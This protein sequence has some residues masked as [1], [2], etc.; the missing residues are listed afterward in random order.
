ML[1]QN[2]LSYIPRPKSSP[3]QSAS[4]KR[5][6]QLLN[7]SL[8][9]DYKSFVELYGNG[10]V[11]GVI[12]I[13]NPFSGYGDWFEAVLGMYRKMREIFPYP[14]YPEPGGLLPFGG[15][16][17]GGLHLMWQTGKDADKWS[18]VLVNWDDLSVEKLNCNM[19]D[20][21]LRVAKREITGDRLNYADELDY[22]NIFRPIF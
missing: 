17:N 1:P 15:T 16:Q 4:W 10:L 12:R 18:V 22:D 20:F 19:A 21:L 9:D 11:C 14:L 7:T 13:H 2:F 3:Y 6:E 8:P 5:V